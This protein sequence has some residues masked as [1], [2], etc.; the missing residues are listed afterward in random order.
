V[1]KQDFPRSA[2]PIPKSVAENF[3][4]FL[5]T[6]PSGEKMTKTFDKQLEIRPRC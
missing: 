1:E 5:G 4:V 6:S 2:S 3:L